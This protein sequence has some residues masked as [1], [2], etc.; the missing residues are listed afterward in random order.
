MTDVSIQ[1][2]V[3][4]ANV[5]LLKESA[6]L[7]V[8]ALAKSLRAAGRE[9]VELGVGEPDF[10]TPAF[11]REAA[12]RAIENGVGHYT[13]TEGIAPLR[14]AIAAEAQEAY[15]GPDPVDPAD[16]VV[17]TGSKQALF[18]ACFVLF[19]AG[20]EVL[21]PTPGWTSYYEMVT[22]ARATPVSVAGDPSR[23]LKV[24][25]ESLAASATSRTRGVILNSPTN[26]TGAV[27]DAAEL[28]DILDLAAERGWW[29]ISDE[30]YRRLSYDGDAPSALE[31]ARDRDRLVVV[32]GVAKAYAMTGWRIGWAI[33]PRPVARAMTALQSHTTSNAA[34]V[35]QHAALAALTDRDASER[36]VSEMVAVYTARR[37]ELL[38]QLRAEPRLE[39]VH[40]AGA[41][42]LYVRVPGA[43]A[44][45][46]APG[47]ALAQHLLDRHGVAVVPGAAFGTADW[48]RLSYAASREQL[49]VGARRLI[50][51]AR[52]L[53]K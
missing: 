38:A 12:R 15:R 11:I 21:L 25:A 4:S 5:A 37:A 29:I 36:A 34:A 16:V 26:P 46:E 52:E 7:A 9:V 22:L 47:T 44:E 23:S 14:Q 2:F 32:N 10:E 24:S 20:D 50:A 35:S 8:A 51:T 42:Y 43:F 49:Q 3:P 45:H 41:F 6:T 18:N 1:P 33:A 28:R 53:V 17:G 40:P 48:V 31:L 30:I 19:G 13:A 39:F 27:Y